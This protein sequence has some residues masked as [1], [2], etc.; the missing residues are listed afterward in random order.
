MRVRF[1]VLATLV[2]LS[3]P[4]FYQDKAVYFSV[5]TNKTFRPN[6]KPKVQLYA[7]N[8][9]VL[10]FRVYRINDPLK[11]FQQLDNVHHFGPEY[12]PKQR[13]DERTWLEK[14]H[15]WKM[16]WW[17]WIRNFFRR[18]YTAESRTEIRERHSLI[19]KRSGVS[20]NEFAAVPVLN[21]QQ[22][23]ARWKLECHRNTSVNHRT[24]PWIR[25][26]RACMCSKQPTAAI[27]LIR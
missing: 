7:N 8:V 11:F 25:C 17:R 15:D 26:L 3:L 19:G 21:S 5:T 12:S 4:A 9:D 24:C 27:A 13:V 16:S 14:V 18:Q 6:E 22:L 23:V 20:A 10:E 1:A 2:L